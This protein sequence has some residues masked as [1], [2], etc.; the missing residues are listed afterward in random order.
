VYGATGDQPLREDSATQPL[1]PYGQAKLAVEQAL[2][3]LERAHG[4][5]SVCLRYFNAAGADPGNELGE[6]HDPE[7]H[8][9]PR[10]IGAALGTDRLE[11]FGDD[12]ATP[13]GTCLR[14][15]VHVVD[16]ADAHLRALARLERG[17]ASAIYNVGSERP[18]SVKDV[19]AAVE[20][21]TGLRVP[22]TLSP[23]RPGD[24]AVLHASADRIRQELGWE[25]QRAD[26]DVI[27]A[28]AWRWHSTH[29]SGF[30]R[31]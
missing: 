18:S 14:D 27:V 10:A 19:V 28:D 5:R 31:A 13:D 4:V 26:L 22:W 17:E 7:F 3:H 8:L 24:P 9:I 30:R 2:P 23:R 21:V 29:P 15:Y 20:R 6:A 11:I 25:P 16:L 1:S 12:Y